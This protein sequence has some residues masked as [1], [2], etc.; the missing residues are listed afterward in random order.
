MVAIEAGSELDGAVAEV[1]GRSVTVHPEGV[2]SPALPIPFR[3]SV[4]LNSA[5]DAVEAVGLFKDGDHVL[6]QEVSDE[7][8]KLCR[9][10]NDPRRSGW[11]IECDG[12]P[13]T[14]LYPTPS[15]AICAAILELAKAK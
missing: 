6:R 2:F 8:W 10:A 4:D 13:V 1:V 3:P 5:F 14:S 9:M 12:C 11:V 15:L 7:S